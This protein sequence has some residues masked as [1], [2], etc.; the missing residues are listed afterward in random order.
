M[1][2]LPT[3]SDVAKLAQVSRQT[4]SN[5]LNSPEI[6][7]A[8]TLARVLEA[9]DTLG[10]RTNAGARR[11]RTQRSSTI[12]VRFEPIS[13]GVSGGLLDRFLHAITEQADSLGMRIL[14]FTAVSQEEEI[15]KIRQ[16]RAGSDIDGVVLAST[17]H[18][19]RRTEWLVRDRTPFVM[20]GRPWGQGKAEVPPHRWVDVDGATGVKE[21]TSHLLSVGCERILFLGWPSPSGTGDDRRNGWLEALATHAAASSSSAMRLWEAQAQLLH[22][23]CRDTLHDAET[24]TREALAAHPEVDGIVCASDSLAIGARIATVMTGRS[25]I[26]V[27]GF[28]NSAVAQAL[29]LS[30][31]DQ[32]LDLVAAATLE[33]LIPTMDGA[34]LDEADN[35]RLISP[36]LIVRDTP[37]V[38][39]LGSGEPRSSL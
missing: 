24:A 37:I 26:P 28:D 1:G 34:P 6:V 25:D 29:G 11:L 35:H 32:R 5:A 30:S 2:R 36:Q 38:L 39:P 15:A 13:D 10:Y 3:V 23:E 17:F 8:T 16:L 22:V 21:A 12:G 14:L 9:V 31:V 19:D 33:L 20:F 18:G 27:V 4:V 7:K